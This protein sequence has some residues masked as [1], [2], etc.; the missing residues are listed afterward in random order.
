VQIAKGAL[1]LTLIIN[2]CIL[3][4]LLLFISAALG[5]RVIAAAGSDSKLDV[6]KRFGGADYIIN[7]SKPGWQK[8]VL[9]ITQGKGVDVIYD[10]VGLVNGAFTKQAFLGVRVL[11]CAF[12][13]TQV[14]RL[15]RTRSRH[16]LRWR[17]H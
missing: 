16:W 17:Y 2:I 8:T 11:I 10:P 4:Y 14:Y 7:Y 12:R 6:V 9:E 1:S 13:F 5:A 3:T 15:E